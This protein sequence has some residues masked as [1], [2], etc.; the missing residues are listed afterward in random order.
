MWETSSFTIFLAEEMKEI[1]LLNSNMIVIFYIS[2][3]TVIK[4]LHFLFDRP[5]TWK[6]EIFIRN[7]IIVLV[8]IMNRL[9]FEKCI[10]CF[11]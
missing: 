5:R 7:R 9:H 2:N 3:F 1:F 8:V 10:F 11:D 6:N 4:C